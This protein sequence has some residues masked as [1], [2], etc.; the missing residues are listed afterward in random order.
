MRA[1]WGRCWIRIRVNWYRKWDLESWLVSKRFVKGTWL[2]KHSHTETRGETQEQLSNPWTP[3]KH[4]L[5][6]YEHISNYITK[7]CLH[8]DVQTQMGCFF[9]FFSKGTGNIWGGKS[10]NTF[11]SFFQDVKQIR[12]YLSISV[13]QALHGRPE[14]ADVLLQL[15]CTVL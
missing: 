11:R 13:E 3:R 8:S 7:Q 2:E 4:W 15:L 6:R 9:F 12:Q 10:H 1:H 14:K 5:G